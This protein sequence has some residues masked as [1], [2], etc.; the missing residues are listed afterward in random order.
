MQSMRGERELVSDSDS[1]TRVASICDLPAGGGSVPFN[2][3]ENG[4]AG[5]EGRARGSYAAKPLYESHRFQGR[6]QL[7]G[8]C[9]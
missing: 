6:I 1:D 7:R 9:F 3:P 4:L 5:V 2:L 8:T